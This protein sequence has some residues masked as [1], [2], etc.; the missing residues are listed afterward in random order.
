MAAL[1]P[2]GGALPVQDGDEW[3]ELDGQMGD[4]RLV[5]P[6]VTTSTGVSEELPTE[7]EAKET[8][9]KLKAIFRC[10]CTNNEQL[11]IRPCGI[12]NGRS[13]MYHHEA[14][15]NVLVL[16]EQIYSL[17][18][19]RKPRHLIYDSN[20]NALHE[21]RSCNIQFFDGMGMCVDAFHHKTKHKANDTLCREHC[22]MRAYP[23]LLHDDGKFYFNSSIAEQT[24]VWFGAFHN[25]CREMTP[26]R[27]DFF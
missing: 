1:L 17:P 14:V 26:V 21:V 18:R 6:T 12:I 3:Y 7:C 20:C 23:E 19:A 11:V 10:Q 9:V 16:I 13:T 15:S 4:T 25:I 22:D 2:T 27:Y 5:Q 8:Q 24:N